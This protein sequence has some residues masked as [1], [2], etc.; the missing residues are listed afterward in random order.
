MLPPEFRSGHR[1]ITSRAGE[2]AS[3][4]L[5]RLAGVAA[6]GIRWRI[7]RGPWFFNMLS[8]LEFDGRKARIR[9]ERA[10]AGQAGTPR[11][12]RVCETELC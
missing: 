3:R 5:A 11:L 2:L 4:A 6:P 9:F 1:L 8:G 12:E 10:V 7:T